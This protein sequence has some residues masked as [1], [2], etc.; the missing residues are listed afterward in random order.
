MKIVKYITQVILTF[1]IA[2]ASLYAQQPDE[3]RL[4]RDIRIAESILSE[5]FN[6]SQNHSFR[7]P[8]TG[9]VKGEYIRGAGVHFTI[10]GSSHRF[11]IHNLQDGEDVRVEVRSGNNTEDPASRE[12]E[13]REKITEYFTTYAPLIS[14]LPQGE[15]IRVSYGVNNSGPGFPVFV[16]NG[17]RNQ[18][19]TPSFTM[20]VN[21][22][23]LREFKAG[24]LSE[25]RFTE[26]I[27]YYD[28]SETESRTDLNIFASVLEAALQDAEAEHL[29]VTGK[30]R[31][32]YLPGLGVHYQVNI[33]PNS[34]HA[35][36][37][38]FDEDFEIRLDSTMRNLSVA[39]ES[40]SEK[41]APL[42]EKMGELYNSELSRE[43]RDSIRREARELRREVQRQRDSV[44]VQRQLNPVVSRTSAADTLDLSA[45]VDAITNQLR[46][47]LNDYG[48]TLTSLKDDELLMI[49]LNWRGR[50]ATLPERTEVRI[51]KSDLVRGEAPSVEEIMRR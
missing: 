9:A 50:N 21:A 7:I 30:P 6:G 16:F 42:A 22:S 27:N 44:Q 34:R 11:Q 31:A 46:N 15:S 45:D 49:T 38:H 41:M 40:L 25:S 13:I 51:K 4:N 37:I 10:S 12:E 18:Q 36:S 24:N 35:F 8:G 29:R 14:E 43:E 28:L 39:M 26:R 47:V 5:M 33:S 48:S 17:S 23:D 19:E 2:S 3:E 1:L 20:W 32:D